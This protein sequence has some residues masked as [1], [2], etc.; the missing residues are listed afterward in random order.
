MQIN[1]FVMSHIE[2]IKSQLKIGLSNQITHKIEQ[3][4]INVKGTM[5]TKKN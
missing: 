4:E 3:D 2:F 5:E 1:L